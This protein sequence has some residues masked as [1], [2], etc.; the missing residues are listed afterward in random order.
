MKRMNP[1]RADVSCD[2]KCFLTRIVNLGVKRYILLK[3][4]MMMLFLN[5][6]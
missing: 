4:I 1:G 2:L 5:F 3:L 6:H